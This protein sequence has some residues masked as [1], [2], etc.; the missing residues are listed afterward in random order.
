MNEGFAM[1]VEKEKVPAGWLL[2]DAKTGE[3][4]DV[5]KAG[6]EAKARRIAEFVG[7][8]VVVPVYR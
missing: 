7:D 8:V 3:V 1:E 6:D 4:F 2:E 5:Y